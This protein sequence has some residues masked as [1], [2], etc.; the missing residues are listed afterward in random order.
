MNEA[1]F[2][3]REEGRVG[4]FCES[5]GVLYWRFVVGLDHKAAVVLK[6]IFE[7]VNVMF[8]LNGGIELGDGN[9]VLYRQP[10]GA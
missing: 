3:V 9:I 8:N 2:D 5:P 10:F 7:V 6:R 4:G 1:Y